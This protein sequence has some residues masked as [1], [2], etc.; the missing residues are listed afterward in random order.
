M[1][2]LKESLTQLIYIVLESAEEIPN[3]RVHDQKTKTTT[4]KFRNSINGAV[5][6]KPVSVSNK[7]RPVQGEWSAELNH[8]VFQAHPLLTLAKHIAEFE[9]SPK[10]KNGGTVIGDDHIGHAI[11]TLSHAFGYKVPTVKQDHI[12]L[13]KRH[14]EEIVNGKSKGVVSSTKPV[15]H[16]N[17]TDHDLS[18]A[19]HEDTNNV[20]REFKE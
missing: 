6:T 5:A 13:L 17:S 3:T 18:L 14:Y 2:T 4:A 19:L 15:V 12:N 11:A 1:G 16:R 10:R 8:P 7:K 9:G 20:I